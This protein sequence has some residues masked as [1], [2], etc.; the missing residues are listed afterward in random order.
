[1]LR[2][3]QQKDHKKIVKIEASS[4]VAW[5]KRQKKVEAT[6]SIMQLNSV[7]GWDL[8]CLAHTGPK[9]KTQTFY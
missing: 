2:D 5:F 4:M 8:S 6:I 9:F 3:R 7:F 1:M